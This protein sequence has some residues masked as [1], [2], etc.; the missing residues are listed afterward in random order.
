MPNFHVN[1]YSSPTTHQINHTYGTVSRLDLPLHLLLPF[2]YNYNLHHVVLFVPIY[3][4]DVYFG[5]S[6]D[7][8]YSVD[9]HLHAIFL[10]L[11]FYLLVHSYLFRQSQP[12]YEQDWILVSGFVIQFAR[13]AFA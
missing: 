9:P 12:D 10:G 7:P 5:G 6:D 8:T 1:A 13:R 3:H 4:R 11:F 2:D